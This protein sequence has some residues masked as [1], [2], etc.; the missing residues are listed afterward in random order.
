LKSA[1]VREVRTKF[2]ERLIETA[3]KG[4]LPKT[5][6]GRQMFR[7]LKVY[8]GAAHRHA[9]QQPKTLEIK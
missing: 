8:R 1:S 9:S 7:K 3:V 4:M 5:P 2:P 6:L